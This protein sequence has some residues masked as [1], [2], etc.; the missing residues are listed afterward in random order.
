[1]SF[2]RSSNAGTMMSVYDRGHTVS[3]GHGVRRTT[4][5]YY[6]INH[7]VVVVS[8]VTRKCKFPAVRPSHAPTIYAFHWQAVI[9]IAF[10]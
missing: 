5:Y 3:T 1:M 6:C 10:L 4:Y 7:V 2:S 8:T 9:V